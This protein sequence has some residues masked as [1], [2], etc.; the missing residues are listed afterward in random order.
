MGAWLEIAFSFYQGNVV[1]Q[2]LP[3]ELSVGTRVSNRCLCRNYCG[4]SF[5]RKSCVVQ[6]SEL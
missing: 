4:S 1:G 6:A 5:R 3:W 2:M